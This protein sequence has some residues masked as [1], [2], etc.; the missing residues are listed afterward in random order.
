[1]AELTKYMHLERLGTSEVEGIENGVCY[2]FPK[3]DFATLNRFCI[4]KIKETRN[5]L[6]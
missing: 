4:M 3:L 1:M 2:V 6:F 5:D